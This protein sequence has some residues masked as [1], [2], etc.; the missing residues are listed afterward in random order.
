MK[1]YL[2]YGKNKFNKKQ[3]EQLRLNLYIE[4]VSE[5]TITYTTAF[6][7]R[8]QQEY[9]EG[10]IPSTILLEMGINPTVLGKNTV[11]RVIRSGTY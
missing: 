2:D 4:K 6:K 10:K 5:T 8:F 7:E 1:E 11:K 9:Q 3:M